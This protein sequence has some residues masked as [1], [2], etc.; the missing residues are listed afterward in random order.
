MSWFNFAKDS[1]R[2]GMCDEKILNYPCPECGFVPDKGV[3]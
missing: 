1:F 2:C 3:K